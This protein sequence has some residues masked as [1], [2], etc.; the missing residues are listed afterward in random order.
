MNRPKYRCIICGYKITPMEKQE[1]LAEFRTIYSCPEKTLV[2]GV[3][4]RRQHSGNEWTVPS[5]PFVRWDDPHYRAKDGI[6]V[7]VMRQDPLNGRHGFVLHDSCW[8]IMQKA[9]EPDSVPLERLVEVCRSLPLLQSLDAVCWG[10]DYGGLWA[11]FFED[12]CTWEDI[13]GRVAVHGARDWLEY[14]LADPCKIPEI[15]ELLQETAQPPKR[16]LTI[17]RKD[18]FGVLPWEVLE[19]IAIY[20]STRDAVRL[21][22][23]SKS[24]LPLSTSQYF[25]ASRFKPGGEY[26]FMFEMWNVKESRDWRMLCQKVKCTISPGIMNR[27]RIWTLIQKAAEIFHLKLSRDLDGNQGLPPHKL[28]CREVSGN[29]RQRRSETFD[30]EGCCVLQKQSTHIPSDLYGVAFSV[31]PGERADYLT[32]IRLLSRS[33]GDICLGY[34]SE[35]REEFYAIDRIRGLIVAVGSR[36]IR[37][38]QVVG[39]NGCASKWFG[40]PKGAPITKRLWGS[41]CLAALEIGLDGYKVVSLA[42]AQS[43]EPKTEEPP[44]LRDT[45]MWSAGIPDQSLFLNE[46]SHTGALPRPT[47][48]QPLFWVHFGGPKGALLSSLVQIS[49]VY[50]LKTLMGFAFRY[51]TDDGPGDGQWLQQ[52]SGG[53]RRLVSNFSID[54]PGGEFIEKV[55]IGG[56]QYENPSRGLH[57]KSFFKVTTNRGRSKC[58]ACF[59]GWRPNT[60][61]SKPLGIAPGTTITGFYGVQVFGHELTSLGVI[62]EIV[63]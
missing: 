46:A 27:K 17:K 32:G 38:I 24:F 41:K 33:N 51:E 57:P 16:E 2:S 48:Y 54:G 31:I 22:R 6:A 12:V 29:I 63:D 23:A 36:G 44:S 59:Y 11:H 60:K 39:S 1:W 40:S 9:F 4:Q 21:Q 15:S 20:L 26:D 28:L 3:G 13:M 58:F 10:H 7:P 19:L 37:G 61:K 42:V 50:W 47:K 56:E 35:R 18:C 8:T 14:A 5:D 25:W 49:A 62:S 43:A 53:F 30:D 52:C 45:A 34:L 55:E